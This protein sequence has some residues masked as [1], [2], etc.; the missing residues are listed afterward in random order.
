MLCL[1]D[2]VQVDASQLESII[3][4]LGNGTGK[5]RLNKDCSLKETRRWRMSVL[6]SGEERLIDKVEATGKKA[7]SGQAVRSLEIN[8]IVSEKDGIYNDLHGFASGAELSNYFKTQVNEYYGTATEASVRALVA[9]G[10]GADK[11]VKGIYQDMVANICEKFGLKEV[12]DGE[13]RRVADIFALCATAGSLASSDHFG[14]FTHKS[15][16]IEEAIYFVFERWLE[17]RGGKKIT[18]KDEIVEELKSFLVQ[19]DH[20]LKIERVDDPANGYRTQPDTK[21]IHNC[22]GY[23]K[24]EGSATVYWIFPKLF[25]KEFPR[26]T[27][28]SLKEVKK[29]LNREG[30]LKLNK[31]GQNMSVWKE[32][33]SWSM[34]TLVLP[35]DNDPVI[36][37]E[38]RERSQYAHQDELSDIGDIPGID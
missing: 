15:K 9:K 26:D 4:M 23:K 22:L 5:T 10:E 31:R 29:I 38:I 3:F 37:D 1:D 19:N 6:S 35:T 13:V 27:G 16:D 34:V 7:L 32:G 17:D 21:S 30:I 12:A 25:Q 18:D 11:L 2:V 36:R 8:A 24:D 20:R 33:R 28:I 14:I